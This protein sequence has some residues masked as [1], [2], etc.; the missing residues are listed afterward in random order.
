[1]ESQN[2]KRVYQLYDEE[3]L[4]ARSAA[5]KKIVPP[6]WPS[7][8]LLGSGCGQEGS[9]TKPGVLPVLDVL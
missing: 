3:K 8:Q 1:M 9:T 6:I 2:A 5:H 7:S 4:K